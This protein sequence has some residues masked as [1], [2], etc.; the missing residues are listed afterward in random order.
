MDIG[1]LS[2]IGIVQHKEHSP[3]VFHIPP[4]TPCIWAFTWNNIINNN[5]KF[6]GQMEVESVSKS[7]NMCI[8]INIPKS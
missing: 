4:G 7:R 2:Y 3:E 5:T 8:Y 6:K 1:V